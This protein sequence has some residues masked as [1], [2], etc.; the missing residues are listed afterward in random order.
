MALMPLYAAQ[1]GTEKKGK[2]ETEIKFCSQYR[3][4]KNFYEIKKTISHLSKDRQ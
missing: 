4:L 3:L 2:P 1:L